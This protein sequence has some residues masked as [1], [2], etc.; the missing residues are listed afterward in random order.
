[1]AE[2]PEAKKCC[3]CV[4]LRRGLLAWVYTK[5]LILIGALVIVAL[6]YALLLNNYVSNFVLGMLIFAQ[7]MLSLEIIFDI[8]FIVSAHKKKYVYL[9]I[10][11]KYQLATLAN[12]LIY[13]VGYIICVAIEF[14]HELHILGMFVGIGFSVIGLIALHVYFVY[15]LR[16]EVRKLQLTTQFKFNNLGNEPECSA[17]IL[18]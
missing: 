9:R 15:L 14:G 18:E 6:L 7:V 11:Y 3:F 5:L 16:S 10:Y 13:L 2:I 17:E 12:D 8:V 1:M 4:P